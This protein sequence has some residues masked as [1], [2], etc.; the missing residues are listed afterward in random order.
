M[1]EIAEKTATKTET[2]YTFVALQNVIRQLESWLYA[3]EESLERE[4]DRDTPNDERLD[5]Y[6]DRIECLQ[7]A[8]DSLE[9]IER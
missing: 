9:A 5:R 8:V 4:E 6:N 3:A 1:A 2:R 7:N